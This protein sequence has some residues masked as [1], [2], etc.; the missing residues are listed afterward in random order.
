MTPVGTFCLVLHSHLPLLA[1]HGRWPVGEEWL[2]QSWAQSY[3]PVVATLRE[4]AAEGRGQLATLGITPVLAAQLDDPYCL[5]GV[6]DWLGGWT[7]R[8]HSAAG[9]LSDLAAHEHR[10]STAATAEFETHWRH[11]GSP[12]LRA[13]R[14][15]GTVELLG[16]PAAHPFQPL[17]RPRV[18]RF[19]LRAGLADHDLRLGGRPAGIWAPECGYAPGMEDDYAAAGVR[20]FLVDG[21]ALR[22]D[23]AL[24]RPVGGSGV[25]CVGRDLE[26]TYRVWSPRRGYPGSPEYRDFHTWDHPSG[27]K[28]ARVTGRRVPPERKKPYSPSL[29][30]DAVRRDARDFVDTVVARLRSLRESTGRP[31][32]TVAAFDTELFGHWWHEGPDWL[33][34]VLRLLP[35]AGVDVRTLGGAIEDGLVGEPVTL[36]ECSWGSGKDWRVWAGPQVSDLLALGDDVQHHL[37]SGVDTVWPG[38]GP[39]LRPDVRDPLADLLVDQAL[40]ALSSDWAF[41][42]TKDSAAGYA[43]SRAVTHAGRVAE[44]SALLRQDR[45][46]AA[47]RRIERWTDVAVPTFGHVDARDLAGL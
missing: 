29:A 21:P 4:L 31:A 11:G 8:A 1:R 3:L 13:L 46:R 24:A 20:R 36:P 2:Y 41:M 27:L 16:G 33:A 28:P 45:R 15:S 7:L 40:H 37:L 47:L 10:V 5:R 6:H 34:A 12:V 26:V 17:L 32:L 9:R 22:G 25:L 23:T 35:E 44:L 42:V 18:R 43:R 14:D 19:S 38:S 39:M 30:A